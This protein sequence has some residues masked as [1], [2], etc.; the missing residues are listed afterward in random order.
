MGSASYLLVGTRQ[1]MDETFGSTCHGAGRVM[2]RKAAIRATKG[3]PLQR[4]LADQGIF[5]RARGRTTL[6]EEAP[7]AYKDVNEVVKAAHEAGI[8]KRVARMRP[9][10]VMKG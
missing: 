9:L 10:A 7:E 1:A 2:S 5:V 3:R 8:S 4:E 6:Q